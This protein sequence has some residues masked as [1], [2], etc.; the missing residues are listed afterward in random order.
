MNAYLVV[1]KPAKVALILF[2]L[3]VLIAIA[4][5]VGVAQFRNDKEHSVR[6]TEQQLSA[7]RDN[8]K[9]LSFDLATLQRLAAKYQQLTRLGLV[10]VADRDG[11]AQRLEGIYRDTR[12]PTTLS[13][14]LAPP[15][16]MNPQGDDAQT[17]YLKNVSHHDLTIEISAIHELEL[18]D[19]ID[20]LNNDWRAP[21]RAE[22]CQIARADTSEPIAGLQIRCTLQLYSIPGKAG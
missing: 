20:K 4:A 8:L 16:A 5:I 7:M 17:A 2:A 10:G 1:L 18:L 19:F 13:Y 9:K 21:Y 14:T 15:Q 6:Q 11:W 3:A 22:T 12:L